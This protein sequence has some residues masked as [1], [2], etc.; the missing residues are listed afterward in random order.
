[1]EMQNKTVKA[2]GLMSGGLD[3][4][5]ACLLLRDQGIEVTGICFETPFFSAEKAKKAA[6]Q[7]DIPLIVK[8]IFAEYMPMLTNPN[9]GYGRNMNPCMDCHSLMFKLAGEVMEAEGFDFL[10][11]G[12][13][14]GQRPMSQ[15]RTSLQYVLKH[16]GHSAK[17]L[18][19][20]SALRLAETEMERDGLVDRSRLGDMAG[21]SRKPQKEMAQRLGMADVPQSG[22]GCLLTDPIFAVR[23]R[24]L[25]A[26]ETDLSENNVQL[27][28]YGR[29]FRLNDSAKL[30]VG[31]DQNDNRMLMQYFDKD[32]HVAVKATDFPGPDCIFT[33]EASDPIL[34]LA[35]AIAAGYSRAPL[36][37]LAS[38]R[39]TAKEQTQIIK[40][41][42]LS[43]QDVKNKLI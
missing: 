7:Y 2:L 16:S 27:L 25:L 19:P 5:L 13:V 35:G 21:R 31:R 38:V 42:P 30:I 22:G 17:I 18:R 23:L 11:S 14:L 4:I 12:E 8:N 15:T 24:D 40:V 6:K 36:E 26:H 3:S 9:V 34:M 10:F 43:P 39:L 29:H 33:G 37:S 41:L 1:M 28:N 20:L 32:K